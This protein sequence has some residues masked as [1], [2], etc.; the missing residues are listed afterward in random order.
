MKRGSDAINRRKWARAMHCRSGRR[1]PPEHQD[2]IVGGHLDD[3]LQRETG[4]FAELLQIID[5]A[6]APF[7]VSVA[8]TAV[9][10]RIADGG[11]PAVALERPLQE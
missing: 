9:E 4:A 10:Y 11:V 5:V 3:L 8:K 1:R 6:H 2:Q 7:G